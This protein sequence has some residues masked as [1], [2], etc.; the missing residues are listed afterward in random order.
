M[1]KPNDQQLVEIRRFHDP[2]LAHITAGSLEANGFHPV[3]LG[4]DL[5]GNRPHLSLLTGVRLFVPAREKDEASAFIERS[6]RKL[7]VVDEYPKAPEDP[8]KSATY[9]SLFCLFLPLIPA[10]ASFYY[11][12]QSPLSL[13]LLL[14][15][16][17]WMIMSLNLGNLFVSYLIAKRLSQLAL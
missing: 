13:R 16:S 9:L 17:F 10:L 8:Y 4:D 15:A 12:A 6:E 2:Y 14:R 11:L 1:D 3:V 5:G 7:S